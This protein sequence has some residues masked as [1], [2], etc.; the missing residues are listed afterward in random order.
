MIEAMVEAMVDGASVAAVGLA[1][2]FL[3]F[4]LGRML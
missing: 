4:V 3:G 2:F 1:L